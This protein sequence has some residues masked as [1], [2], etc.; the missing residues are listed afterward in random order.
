MKI[1]Q[2]KIICKKVSYSGSLDPYSTKAKEKVYRSKQEGMFQCLIRLCYSS[3][4]KCR[5]SH[6]E[7]SGFTCTHLRFKKEDKETLGFIL[8][9]WRCLDIEIPPK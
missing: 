2:G 9:L 4:L 6:N 3:G 7:T 5:L 8:L 1:G